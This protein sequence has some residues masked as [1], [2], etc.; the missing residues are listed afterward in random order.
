MSKQSK[1][2]PGLIAI[3]AISTASTAFAD[4]VHGALKSRV[5]IPSESV[6]V[7]KEKVSIPRNI[8]DYVDAYRN[9][10]EERNVMNSGKVARKEEP[11]AGVWQKALGN[12]V[13]L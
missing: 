2:I 5:G 8:Q 10:V 13:K 1:I 3:I 6:T 7:S 12:P 11:F 4:S 9:T